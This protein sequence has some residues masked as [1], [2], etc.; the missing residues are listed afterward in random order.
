LLQSVTPHGDGTHT[1]HWKTE[2]TLPT[3][4]VSV[5]IGDYVLVADTFAGMER[6]VPITYYVRPMDADKVPGSFQNIHEI[7]ANLEQRFG[8]Y[9]FE[10]IGYSGTALGAMEHAG[11]IAYPNS[12]IVNNTSYEWLYTHEIAHMWFGN[13]V[14]C[15]G[16]GD[17]WLNEGWAVWTELL[18]R[19]DLYNLQTAIDVQ[20]TKHKRILQFAHTSSGDNAYHALYNIPAP[21][22]YGETVYQKGGLVAQ[23]LR[24]Y[25]G[26]ELFFPAVRAYLE[27]FAFGHASSFDLRDFLSQHAGVN[28][29]PFFDSWI[30][31]PGFPHY[32]IDSMIVTEAGTEVFVRQRSKGRDFLGDANIVE[33][34]FMNEFFEIWSDT[35]LF[36][37]QSGSK[38][39]Q[40]PFPPAIAMM[41]YHEKNPRCHYRPCFH[42]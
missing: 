22:V 39:F 28:M 21:Y 19:E 17:M 32:A 31:Q 33:I 26:D 1:F 8:P 20:R 18:Y 27:E 24:H 41:D 5:A 11:N 2:Y 15:A 25:M 37:G 10:R 42:G 4:L 3:Y 9:P 30:F 23:T 12:V 36:D 16:P 35:M 14:T 29:A 34:T 6:D 38:L 7:M 40:P 13:M